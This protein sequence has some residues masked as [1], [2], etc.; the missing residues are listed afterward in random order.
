MSEE[1][2]HRLRINAFTQALA[3]LPTWVLVAWVQ[4]PRAWVV[5]LLGGS[6]PCLQLGGL[7]AWVACG[8]GATEW[9]LCACVVFLKPVRLWLPPC[10]DQFLV[11]GPHAQDQ[12]AKRRRRHR[13]LRRRRRRRR[14]ACPLSLSCRFVSVMRWSFAMLD[15]PAF[16]W[17]FA[18]KHAGL[19]RASQCPSS[20]APRCCS[21]SSS[22]VAARVQPTLG[23]LWPPPPP[24]PPSPRR[25]PW[26]RR[27]SGWSGR[28][29]APL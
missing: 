26:Q 7:V 21:S 20:W 3:Q 2:K 11:A 10:L 1:L 16:C 12:D 5:A 6:I 9:R 4:R 19:L 23:S 8:G 27:H 24:P 13:R 25:P 15:Q 18:R 29:R 17:M 28:R 22:S 14:R